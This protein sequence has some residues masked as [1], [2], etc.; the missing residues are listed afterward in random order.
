MEIKT[1][2]LVLNSK[3]VIKSQTINRRKKIR[4]RKGKRRGLLL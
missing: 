1:E 3:W 4:I 2:L